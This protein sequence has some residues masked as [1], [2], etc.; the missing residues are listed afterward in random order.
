M[1]RKVMAVIKRT[2]K[3]MPLAIHAAFMF[4]MLKIVD[5]MKD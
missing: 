2:P 4:F 3:N 5:Q 1:V